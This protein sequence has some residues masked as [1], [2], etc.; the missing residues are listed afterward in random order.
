MYHVLNKNPGI[1]FSYGAQRC[2]LHK[3]RHKSL[4]WHF[5]MYANNW[6]LSALECKT[7][8]LSKYVK[9]LCIVKT[10][11]NRSPQLQCKYS[12][13]PKHLPHSYLVCTATMCASTKTANTLILDIH[14][15]KPDC[16]MSLDWNLHAAVFIQPVKHDSVCN[17][18]QYAN[19]EEGHTSQGLTR[20]C[21]RNSTKVN[22]ERCN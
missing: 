12:K 19:S 3:C 13:C 14:S 1:P 6:T 18:T 4:K 16:K 7:G 15:A 8:L 20:C 22:T 17:F 2:N 11:V 21:C 10:W 5:S 9:H